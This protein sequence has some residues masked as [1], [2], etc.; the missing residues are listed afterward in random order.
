MPGTA[1]K[2]W[3][4]LTLTPALTVMPRTASKLRGS[5]TLT[6]RAHRHATYREQA[7]GLA[8]AHSSR[9]RRSIAK[10]LA[11]TGDVLTQLLPDRA[12]ERR[13]LVL[14]QPLLEDLARPRRG[15]LGP[16]PHPPLVVLR[17]GQQRPVETGTEPLH[18]VGGAEEM[19]AV[20]YLVM[21][22][23]GQR[24]LVDLERGDLDLQHPQDL[25]IDHELL[26]A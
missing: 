15:V 5:L 20:A 12:V 26:E 1:S 10:L 16:G 4:S 11:A 6:P 14:G 18:R 17:R 9:S 13:G 19:A 2:L 25:D 24:R 7:A 23:E 3:G 8:D 22:V 21:S